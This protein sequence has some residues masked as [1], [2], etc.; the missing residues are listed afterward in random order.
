MNRIYPNIIYIIYE[1]EIHNW[2]S[3]IIPVASDFY[4]Q[5]AFYGYRIT[6]FAIRCSIIMQSLRH[7]DHTNV[8]VVP[9][10]AFSVT[11]WMFSRRI[12]NNSRSVEANR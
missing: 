6:F 4:P 1:E 12:V 11:R 10:L 9:V 7:C 5:Y 2:P 8:T 3:E